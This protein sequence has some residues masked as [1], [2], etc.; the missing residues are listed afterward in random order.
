MNQV[1]KLAKSLSARRNQPEAHWS[2]ALEKTGGLVAQKWLT[3]GQFEHLAAAALSPRQLLV[4]AEYAGKQPGKS[5]FSMLM[6]RVDDSSYSITDWLVAME[7]FHDWISSHGKSTSLDMLLGY[8]ACCTDA[9]P[10]ASTVS[11]LR[12]LVIT[13]LEQFGFDG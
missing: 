4:L 10:N 3:E 7:A 12:D 1:Q 5:D 11:A 6:E 13:M 2:V 8:I 9:D